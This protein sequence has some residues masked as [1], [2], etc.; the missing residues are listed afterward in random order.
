MPRGTYL[1]IVYL[2][3]ALLSFSRSLEGLH[4]MLSNSVLQPIPWSLK[5]PP[6]F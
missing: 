3:A 5:G 6:H 2:S 4:F 1:E